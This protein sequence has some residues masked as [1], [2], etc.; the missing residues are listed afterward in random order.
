MNTSSR[1]KGKL[2]QCSNK[3]FVKHFCLLVQKNP[4]KTTKAQV[5]NTQGY[6]NRNTRIKTHPDL[7][8]E[9]IFA[10]NYVKES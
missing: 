8:I 9:K 7:Q 3:G 5:F 2:F 4:T 6:G 1:Y 10:F